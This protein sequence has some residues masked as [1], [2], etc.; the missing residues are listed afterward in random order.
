MGD[1]KKGKKGA[2]DQI[3][4]YLYIG[5]HS[6][7]LFR[8]IGFSDVFIAIKYGSRAVKTSLPITL[9]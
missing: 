1:K 9:H 6:S 7:C 3:Y 5:F 2:F 4:I 8:S